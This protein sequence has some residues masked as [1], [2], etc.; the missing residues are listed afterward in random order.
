MYLRKYI[1]DLLYNGDTVSGALKE[2]REG[3]S[4]TCGYGL[5]FLIFQPVIIKYSRDS[6]S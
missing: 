3:L 4:W 2:T 1:V 6:D 5:E